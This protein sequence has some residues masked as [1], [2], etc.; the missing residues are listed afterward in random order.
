MPEEAVLIQ[1]MPVE[2]DEI[3]LWTHPAW[4]KDGDEDAI[5][6]S[7]F[8]D[9]GLEAF[10]VELESDGPEEI[11]GQWFEQGLCDCTAWTPSMPPGTGWF[12]F[13]IHDTEDGPICVWV[14]HKVA[15]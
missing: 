1:P 4:P 7:W 3:G 13:S 12:V 5:P 15:P 14:R 10:L 8:A 6:K 11:V 9:Q 2:R